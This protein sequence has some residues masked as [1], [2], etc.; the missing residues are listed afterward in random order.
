[1]FRPMCSFGLLCVAIW[2]FMGGHLSGP[3]FGTPSWLL[4]TPSWILGSAFLVLAI[5]VAVLPAEKIEDAIAYGLVE[6]GSTGGVVNH[7]EDDGS[8]ATHNLIEL[9]LSGDGNDDD[10]N[11][12]DFTHDVIKLNLSSDSNAEENVEGT[13]IKTLRAPS[14]AKPE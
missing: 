3:S 1:M 8:L 5:L 13:E 11:G 12:F 2:L 7:G 4:E 9:G 10:D 6:F 14:D